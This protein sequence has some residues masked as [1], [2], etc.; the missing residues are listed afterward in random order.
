MTNIPEQTQQAIEAFTAAGMSTETLN[1]GKHLKVT[2]DEQ[3]FDFWPTTGK[4]QAYAKIFPVTPERFIEALK[5]GRITWPADAGQ[6]TCNSCGDPI[7]WVKSFN[8][9]QPEK[10]HKN[11]PL[12]HDGSLHF[13]V[14]AGRNKK[15]HRASEQ[16]RRNQASADFLKAEPFNDAIDF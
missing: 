3:V 11:T 16:R 6:A 8:A 2:F 7:W 10:S 4:A 13:P 14:C 15:P 9:F 12:N 5:S 1:E